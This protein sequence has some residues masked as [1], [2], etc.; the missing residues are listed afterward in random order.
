[1]SP[2]PAAVPDSLT[3]GGL[4]PNPCSPAGDSALPVVDADRQ[5]VGLL[6]RTA[7]ERVPEEGRDVTVASVMLPFDAVPAVGPDE[8]LGACWTP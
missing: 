2:V 7:V 8:P 6:E 3:V 4:W 1:M 5:P